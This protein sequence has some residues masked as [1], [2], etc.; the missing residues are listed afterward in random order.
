MTYARIEHG[1]VA[2]YPVY[3]GDLRLQFSNVSFPTP[4]VPPEGYVSVTDVTP[5][6]V[7]YTQ[8]LS[9][10]TPLENA[11]V[12]SR[13]WVVSPASETEIAA[14]I[15]AQWQIVRGQRNAKLA[16]SD[17]TQLDDTPLTNIKK[18]EWAA[19]RHAVREVTLQNDPFAIVWPQEPGA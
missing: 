14:R 4:F 17:W 18:Q 15:D 10:S 6:A 2:E 12:W 1:Q 19:Y 3:E 16:A 5:P 7:N 11:G 13:N 9:E 8:N